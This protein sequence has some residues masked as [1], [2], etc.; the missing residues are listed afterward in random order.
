MKEI[1]S[2]VNDTHPKLLKLLIDPT[3]TLIVV[4]HSNQ[5]GRKRS[6]GLEPGL[7]LHCDK[8]LRPV[9]RAAPLETKD[10]T[11]YCGDAKR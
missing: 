9:V 10:R 8:L 2:W 5:S 4:E 7:C 6:G 11:H 3:I 1:G